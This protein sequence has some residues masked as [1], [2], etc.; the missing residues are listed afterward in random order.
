MLARMMAR[1][2]A[3]LLREADVLVPVPL[4]RRRLFVRRYNQAALLAQALGTMIGRP[5]LVDALARVA[6]T[7]S[8]DGKIG[9][10]AA[11]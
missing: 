1:S 2:G 10:G 5:V 3:G 11:G 8:L 6:A 7:Q 9:G 4:H